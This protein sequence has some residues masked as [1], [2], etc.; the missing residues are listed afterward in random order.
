M[1]GGNLHA[2]TGA[3]AQAF[4]VGQRGGVGRLLV[5]TTNYSKDRIC[6]FCLTDIKRMGTM[7]NLDE[8][9]VTHITR[10]GNV[11][12]YFNKTGLLPIKNGGSSW[13]SARVR[14][15]G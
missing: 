8:L 13:Q 10:K 4:A 15:R 11:G 3:M 7:L 2:E 6:H 9:H 5:D 1:S 14:R 12:Y